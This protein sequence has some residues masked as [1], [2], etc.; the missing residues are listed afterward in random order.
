MRRVTACV[1]PVVSLHIRVKGPFLVTVLLMLVDLVLCAPLGRGSRDMFLTTL[2]S[3]YKLNCVQG[4][5]EVEQ[6]G[7]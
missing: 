2:G 4:K 7:Y 5:K 6:H 3:P 1:L